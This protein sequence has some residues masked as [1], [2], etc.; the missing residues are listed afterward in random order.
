MKFRFNS[1]KFEISVLA[2]LILAFVLVVYSTILFISFRHTLYQDLDGSLGVKAQKINNAVASY[3][4]VLG[5]DPRSFEFAVNRVIAREGA[6]LERGVAKGIP[7]SVV[8]IDLRNGSATP[9]G[10]PAQ[11][12]SMRDVVVSPDGSKLYYT[13]DANGSLQEMKLR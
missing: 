2:I 10:R 1:L 3:L 9:I 13:N 7:D 8:K 4:N 5:Y 6:G 11:D 12:T